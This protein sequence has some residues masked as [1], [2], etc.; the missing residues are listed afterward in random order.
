MTLYN[1][2]HHFSILALSPDTEASIFA[3]PEPSAPLLCAV[4]AVGVLLL[5]KKK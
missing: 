1:L 5:R 4:A 2:T 3:I